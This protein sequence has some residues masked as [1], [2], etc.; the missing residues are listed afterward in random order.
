MSC[1]I[2]YS[3]IEFLGQAIGV[4]YYGL[5]L[6]LPTVTDVM[7]C[8]SPTICSSTVIYIFCFCFSPPSLYFFS[9]YAFTFQ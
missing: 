5:T 6:A 7:E 9:K 4:T 8:P 1:G 2:S 3:R